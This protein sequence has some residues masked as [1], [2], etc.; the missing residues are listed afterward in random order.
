MI[1]ILHSLQAEWLTSAVLSHVKDHAIQSQPVAMYRIGQE[2]ASTNLSQDALRAIASK[3]I[4]T[5]LNL[6]KSS[7]LSVTE[8]VFFFEELAKSKPLKEVQSDILKPERMGDPISEPLSMQLPK[9]RMRAIG[10][11]KMSAILKP[12]LE[13]LFCRRMSTS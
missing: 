3:D 10:K 8:K 2:F 7:E 6:L 11:A 4:R 13:S 9:R 1:A 5:S 12:F